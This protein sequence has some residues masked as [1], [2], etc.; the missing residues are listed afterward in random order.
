MKQQKMAD[1][2]MAD[3]SLWLGMTKHGQNFRR[4]TLLRGG[5]R[6]LRNRQ[7][8][9][10]LE[11]EIFGDVDKNLLYGT[12]TSVCDCRNPRPVF[13]CKPLTSDHLG[14][15]VEVKTGED[16][17]LFDEEQSGYEGPK[18]TH[19]LKNQNVTGVTEG[20]ERSVLGR[21]AELSLGAVVIPWH[22]SYY[23]HSRKL[24]I[25]QIFGQSFAAMT[26]GLAAITAASSST[27]S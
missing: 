14:P 5:H 27:S 11:M 17:R 18:A 19:K 16:F 8:L 25:T 22:F 15:V 1:S 20:E 10:L 4:A 2:K 21:V 24:L 23:S 7:S 13:S 6:F 3:S 12:R 26:A 9:G